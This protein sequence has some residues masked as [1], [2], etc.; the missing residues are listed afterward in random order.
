MVV[1]P[2]QRRA[3]R[4][5]RTHPASAE[6]AFASDGPSPQPAK[7]GVRVWPVGSGGAPR[8]LDAPV[9]TRLSRLGFDASSMRLGWAS[10]SGAL[11]WSLADPPDAAPRLLRAAGEEPFGAL[12][13]DPE[14]RWAAA[15]RISGWLFMW[16]LAS[17]Y[18]RVLQGHTQGALDL[19]FTADSR[20]LASCG[21]DGARLWPL[22]PE[23]GRQR[24]ISLGEEYWCFG[25]AA[26]ATSQSADRGAGAGAPRAAG[27]R[28]AAQA[29][30]ATDL[31]ARPPRPARVSPPSASARRLRRRMAIRR[32]PGLGR[33]SLLP[34]ARPRGEST[35]EERVLARGR[36]D[37]SLMSG[38]AGGVSAGTS[39]P[40]AH[41][42]CGGGSVGEVARRSGA[43]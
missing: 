40:A 28:P 43:G 27:R 30:G 16:S 1:W 6:V 23:D 20:F 14:G 18:P 25:I 2:A 15:G 22:S 33:G 13:F 36:A 29:R 8:T 21:L 4:S 26:D 9:Q 35:N 17:P 41:R 34:A 3:A 12:A 32:R 39:G 24:P 11:V 19:A 31:F 42:I 37:G 5:G 38:G 10:D 7:G